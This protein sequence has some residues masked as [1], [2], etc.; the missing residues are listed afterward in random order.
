M[1]KEAE[2]PRTTLFTVP[3]T[4]AGNNR[5][6]VVTYGPKIKDAIDDG[7]YCGSSNPL[8]VA[9]IFA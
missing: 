1:E 7:R 9:A 6:Y 5:S 3:I 4:P 8:P 2:D